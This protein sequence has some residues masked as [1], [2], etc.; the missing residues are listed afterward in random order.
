MQIK[1]LT[2][3]PLL[4]HM[5]DEENGVFKREWFEEMKETAIITVQLLHI[6]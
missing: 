4:D 2:N 1:C 5:D 3:E 6:E